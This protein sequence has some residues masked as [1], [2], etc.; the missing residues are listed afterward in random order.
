MWCDK[1]LSIKIELVHNDK[2]LKNKE[3]PFAIPVQH[4]LA[5]LQ[6]GIMEKFDVFCGEKQS[7]T[8]P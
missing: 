6:G 3:F 4:S 7:K 1:N 2:I 5:Y 8:P